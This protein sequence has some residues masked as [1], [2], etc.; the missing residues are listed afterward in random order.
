MSPMG[1]DA[2]KGMSAGA[3][4]VRTGDWNGQPHWLSLTDKG[5]G[6]IRGLPEML[7]SV[8]PLPRIHNNR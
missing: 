4:F 1:K 7:H 3:L 6:R 2:R 5:A 8:T